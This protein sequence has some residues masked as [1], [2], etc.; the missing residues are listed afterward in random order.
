MCILNF[1]IGP[2]EATFELLSEI[3]YRTMTKLMR[4]RRLFQSE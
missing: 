3:N 4:R 2:D 1:N